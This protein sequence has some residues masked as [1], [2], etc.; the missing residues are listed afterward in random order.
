MKGL[1]TEASPLNFPA[2]ASTDEDNFVLNMDGS[3]DRRLGLDFELGYTLWGSPYNGTDLEGAKVNTFTWSNVAED[4]NL[5]FAVV[6]IGNVLHFHDMANDVLSSAVQG[7]LTIGSEKTID[8]SFAVVDGK[9][10]VARGTQDITV[11][12]YDAGLDNFSKSTLRVKVRDLFGVEDIDA[13][14][15]NL[16][17]DNNISLRPTAISNE[18]TYNTRNQ[19]WGVPRFCR[20][21]GSNEDPLSSTD[22]LTG[23][24]P[25]NA[26]IMFTYL[27]TDPSDSL[28]RVRFFAAD[29]GDNPPYSAPAPRG[30][31]VIDAL[32]RGASREQAY[33]DNMS[34]FSE[35]NVDL[36]ES[37]PADSTPSGATQ[38]AE[39][40]GRVWYAGFSG[41]VSD[42]DSR[43][44][45][46]SNYVM[47][48]QLVESSDDIGKCYQAGDPTSDS[49]SDLVATDGGFIRISG[50]G[51]I[52]KLIN[53]GSVLF[54]IANNGVWIVMGG[55]DEGF[56]ADNYIVKK[57]SEHT[58]IFR[59]TVVEV[60]DSLV[61]WTEDGIYRVAPDPS[62]G[63]WKAE[64]LTQQTI[65]TFYDE[66]SLSSKEQA[67]GVFDE[68]TRKIRWLYLGN[69]L[70]GAQYHTRELVLDVNLGAFSP[71]TI[72][73][74]TFYTPQ[75]VAYVRTKPFSTSTV[76]TPVTADG[77]QVLADGVELTLEETSR[78]EGSRTLKY[79]TLY[80][81]GPSDTVGYTFSHYYDDNF[82][83]WAQANA[84]TQ[85]TNAY[86][87][88]LDSI[89]PILWVQGYAGIVNSAPRTGAVA[90]AG[91]L[92][93]Y[94]GSAVPDFF[95]EDG[96][97]TG[98][99]GW[100]SGSGW[101][102]TGDLPYLLSID[103]NDYSLT[104]VTD[105]AKYILADDEW[106]W[107]GHSSSSAQPQT[108]NSPDT[109]YRAGWTLKY[110]F[111]VISS[112]RYFTTLLNNKS[113]TFWDENT[114]GQTTIDS[115]TTN[116]NDT[117]GGLPVST[118]GY[119]TIA[120]TA[121]EFDFVVTSSYG[122]SATDG[123]P[124]VTRWQ[125]GIRGHQQ[126]CWSWTGDTWT[127]STSG[128]LEGSDYSFGVILEDAYPTWGDDANMAVDGEQHIYKWETSSTSS[129]FLIEYTATALR[130]NHGS[131]SVDFDRIDGNLVIT[132]DA[133]TEVISLYKDGAL[134]ATDTIVPLPSAGTY[135]RELIGNGVSNPVNRRPLSGRFQHMWM[136]DIAV[137]P[138]NI[139]LLYDSI[140][141]AAGT[142][143]VDAKAYMATGAVTAGDSSRDKQAPFLT[144]HMRQTETTLG[145]DY[146]LENPSGC[147]VQ[148][149][150][151]FTNSS[152][153]N[154]WGTPFQAYRLRRHYIPSAVGADYDSGY[155]IISTRNKVRGSGNALAIYAE[156]EAG[157]DCRIL[158][159]NLSLTGNGYV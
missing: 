152:S 21:D 130:V 38:V 79:L 73:I 53:V 23:K 154:K 155:E 132:Y 60:E 114:S 103:P 128:T 39:Y 42:G 129:S 116:L 139:G 22:N 6:Q 120:G 69:T 142:G 64:N 101:T 148:T 70:V 16:F 134:Y 1:I 30:Y 77:V 9:L 62:S 65:Q 104:G 81:T 110:N 33:A 19:S 138:E 18:H 102:G 27:R 54:I 147:K 35:L 89:D 107:A 112:N 92:T 144:W 76:I 153:S 28:G 97:A 98:A 26:D 127:A 136:T 151:G 84:I 83:D 146:E 17:E 48:S 4:A 88:Y 96:G 123:I 37:L 124:I 159:W 90:F 52:T 149:R 45:S 113:I 119:H 95:Y 115:L 150:W 72:Q 51:T 78:A 24:Y 50:V 121:S 105:P 141:V 122:W 43:S 58:N 12:E 10:V 3:R 135:S 93:Q 106:R 41:A 31:F 49:E 133:T 117:V 67:K 2:D 32:D 5:S 140:P 91:L 66:I 86:D 145:A 8:F 36:F 74:G 108:L 94:A 143:G 85:V 109:P 157:K 25:S 137:S 44:P 68:V 46:L 63:S 55:A 82:V 80:E 15:N 158:G 118:A 34:K 125:V 7:E 47:F 111:S 126:G 57:I 14:S 40:G 11:C 13:T 100:V 56:S 20:D 61:Y 59:D 71:A 156:T 131:S 29:F 75:A 99:G 87:T